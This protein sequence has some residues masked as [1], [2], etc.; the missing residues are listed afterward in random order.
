MSDIKLNDDHFCFACGESNPDGLRVKFEYPEKGRCRAEVVMPRKFQGW[1]GILHGGIIS[2]LLDEAFAHAYGGPERGAGEA[3]V[4][5]EMRVKFKKPVMTGETFLVEGRVVGGKGRVIECESFI[6]D[7][8][9][10][11]L[12]SAEGKLIKLKKA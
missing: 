7:G 3:G 12:A 4:T 9:G 11:V 5:A 1:E 10:Q 2:T 6:K 8:R